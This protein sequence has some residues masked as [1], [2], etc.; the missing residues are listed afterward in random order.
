MICFIVWRRIMPELRWSVPASR[1]SLSIHEDRTKTKHRISIS[2]INVVLSTTDM[3][4]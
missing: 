4:E 3:L 2:Q 1:G